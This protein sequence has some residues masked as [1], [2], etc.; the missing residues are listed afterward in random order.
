MRYKAKIQNVEKMI[1]M[2]SFISRGKN[3]GYID[4]NFYI[5]GFYVDGYILGPVI[6]VCDDHIALEYWCKVDEDTLVEVG[7]PEF[8][9]EET[10]IYKIRTTVE[11]RNE[12]Y[13]ELAY[14]HWKERNLPDEFKT[15]TLKSRN[16]EE[17]E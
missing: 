8:T 11:A 15:L 10:G 9:V 12:G 16:I 7:S 2:G 17:I 13:A 1:K 5:Y 4:D 14:I 6:D 3:L